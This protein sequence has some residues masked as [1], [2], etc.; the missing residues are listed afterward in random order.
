MKKAQAAKLLGI[1]HKAL[2]AD[3]INQAF[4]AKLAETHPDAGGSGGDMEQLKKARNLLLKYADTC[5]TEQTGTR[6]TGRW[7]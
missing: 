1:N 4:R 7:G 5:G 6:R 2:S 3:A